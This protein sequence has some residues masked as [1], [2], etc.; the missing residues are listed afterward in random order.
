MFPLLH[1]VLIPI[2]KINILQ[3]FVLKLS[4][5]KYF[6]YLFLRGECREKER[7]G[8][9]NVW[10]PL[11]CP[12]L[13]T[14]PATQ[15]CAPTGNGTTHPLV[16]RLVLNP[17]SHNSQGSFCSHLSSQTSLTGLRGFQTFARIFLHIPAKISIASPEYH[18]SSCLM[19]NSPPKP[20]KRTLTFFSCLLFPNRLIA[21]PSF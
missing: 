17:L 8:N 1:T 3:S 16:H 7:E 2:H 13:G 11:T 19:G 5:L 6:I 15:A 20:S 18:I 9:I 10:L 14:W 21:L 12:L 4:F